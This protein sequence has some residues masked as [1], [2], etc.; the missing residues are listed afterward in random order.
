MRHVNSVVRPALVL[1]AAFG[2]VAC[3]ETG[4]AEPIA[5]CRTV[6]ERAAL[7]AVDRTR[8]IGQTHV[9]GSPFA[10]APG[11]QRIEVDVFGAEWLVYAVDVTIDPSCKVLATSARLESGRNDPR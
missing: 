7:D 11:M 10:I 4:P 1:A 9:F 5:G 3:N 6:V 2:M 8:P